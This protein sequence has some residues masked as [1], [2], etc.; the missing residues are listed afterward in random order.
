[1]KK[2]R[3]V[4]ADDHQMVRKGFRALLEK[5]ADIQVMGEAED[6]REAMQLVEQMR[7][8]VLVMDL[9]MPGMP[10]LEAVRQLKKRS[11]AVRILIL[12]MH[13]QTNTILQALWNGAAGYALKDAAV[14]DLIEGI[15]TVYHGEVFLSPTIATQVVTRLM[16]GLREEEIAS[17][18]DL[19]T[20]R[21]R[22]VLVLIAEGYARQETAEKLSVSPKT[23]DTHRANLMRKLDLNNDAALVRLAVRYGLVPLDK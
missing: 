5:E 22:E 19:L 17:P 16:E 13:R 11:T 4:L 2:I 3:V 8:D 23:V 10:G 1:M 7:P 14:T 18:L 15:R 20:D 21:E 9:E 12:T 6:G